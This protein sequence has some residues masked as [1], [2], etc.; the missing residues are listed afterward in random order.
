MK[1]LDSVKSDF[2]IFSHQPGLI[3]L[4]S[5]ATALKPQ[6]VINAI[7]DYYETYTANIHRGIYANAETA[8]FEY[9]ATR[10][11]IARLIHAASSSE[12]IFTKNATESLNLIAYTW[13]QEHIQ[14]GDELIVTISEHHANFVPWQQLAKRKKAMLRVILVNKEGQWY[15]EFGKKL[16]SSWTIQDMLTAKTKLVAISHISNVLGAIVP[17]ADIVHVVKAFNAS[18]FCIIDGCQSISHIP[19]DVQ[20]IGADAY[21]FSSH[22]LFGPTGVGVLW[23]HHSVLRSMPPFLFGGDMIDEVKL[24]GTTFKS[25]PG[26]FEAGTPAI[27]EVIGL[28][29]AV[30]YFQ[31]LTPSAVQKKV[32]ALTSYAL[33]SLADAFPKGLHMLGPTDAQTR[34][35]II[36]FTMDGM[37]PHD[38]AQILDEFHVAVRAGH[39]C[40][41]P[42]HHHFGI[43]ATTRMSLH[44]Y[45][46]NHHINAFIKALWGA[47]KQLG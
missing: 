27:G 28:G 47:K 38:I 25:P 44:V 5:A 16:R 12:I 29:A 1:S 31:S 2:P 23:M 18:I 22:K 3:Y 36:A 9:E 45:N 37:H 13:A 10:K 14:A 33:S 30:D 20:K 41:M 34:C 43:S 35:G 7:Q 21:V 4:D 39:H 46:T 6:S 11:K 42:L 26:K 17:V 32:T 19:V 8:S 15:G 24:T 40:A